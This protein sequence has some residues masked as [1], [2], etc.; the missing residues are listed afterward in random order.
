M[1]QYFDIKS[2]YPDTILLFQ[3]G[4]FYELFFE[5]AQKAASVLGIALTKRGTH[6]GEPIPLCGVPLHVVDHYLSKLVRAGFKVALCDQL[7]QPKPG[8]V[9]ER[10]V[11]QVLTPGTLTD[12]KLLDEKSASYLGIFFPTETSW[13]LLAAELLT[14]HLFVT[15]IADKSQTL[16]DAELA[17]LMPD[18]ILLPLTKL[19]EHYG[20]MFQSQGYVISYEHYKHAS[21]Q[22]GVSKAAADWFTQ[23]F[24]QSPQANPLQPQSPSL[25]GAI[26]LLYGYLK[27]NN[28]QGLLELKH[29]SFYKPED[30]MMLD[31]ITQRNLELVK[32][33]T[34]GSSANSLFHVL[35]KAVTAMGS[36][37]IKKW[38]LRPLIKKERIEERLEA[39][40]AFVN[41]HTHKTQLRALLQP[42]G[43]L[44]RIVGRIALNRAQLHDYRALLQALDCYSRNKTSLFLK[45]AKQF[46]LI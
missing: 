36:R 5:D 6:N 30:Y 9:V 28:E 20:Q 19:G 7:E 43:D 4:D 40:E 42:V 17:R 35:D 11:T 37:M 22:S 34:D 10:G 27:R 1:R 14:G 16:L 38:L 46:Y 39:V 25:E 3:V 31:A 33:M 12:T 21:A 8:K 15:I 41:D 44:E 24:S 26:E 45:R 29:L 23:Q 2:K 13:A 18:E 32:N